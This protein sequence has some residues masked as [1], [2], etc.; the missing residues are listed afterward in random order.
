LCITVSRSERTVSSLRLLCAF[1]CL[2]DNIWSGFGRLGRGML[3]ALVGFG[4]GWD[5]WVV[6]LWGGVF[7]SGC[8]FGGCV[9]LVCGVRGGRVESGL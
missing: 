6:G 2:V 5:G 4:Y 7:S 1:R 8:W 9:V 3:S